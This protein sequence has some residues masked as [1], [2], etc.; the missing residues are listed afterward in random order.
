M[1]HLFYGLYLV[2]Y[3]GSWL[4][5][6]WFCEALA[7]RLADFSCW[8]SAKD[9]HAVLENLKAILGQEEVPLRMVQEVFRNFGLYLVDFFRFS[10]LTPEAIRRLVRIEGEE[11]M[12]EVLAQG[13]GAI[14]LT[15]HLGNYELAGA[16]LSLLGFPVH[17]VVL[18]HQNPQV[19]AFFSRQRSR[20]GVQGIPLK[21]QG[22][23]QAVE[24]SLAVLRRGQILG[25]VGDRDYLDHGIPLP[26]F[27]RTLKVPTGPASFSL[28]TGAPIVPGFLVREG[29]SY[30]FILEKPI[31]PPQTADHEQAQR[32]LTQACLEAM[33]R[34]IRQYPTQW[35]MFQEF[36]KMG[37][38]VV[39]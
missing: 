2:G 21:P 12:R 3:W 36:W 13:R 30:R 28:K 33:A 31:F 25:L 10:R 11:R 39:L 23:R 29:K 17:A 37:P 7:R 5:P 35:Y 6:R 16:V 38:A 27:G 14:A 4:L 19:D 15:A 9:R 22:I 1:G 34:Y 32:E 8:R 18:T 26:L 20:V 24:S